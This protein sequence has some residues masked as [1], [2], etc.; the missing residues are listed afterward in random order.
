MIDLFKKVLQETVVFNTKER[1]ARLGG[2]AMKAENVDEW[3]RFFMTNP[4]VNEYGNGVANIID[5]AIVDE[6]GN[7]TS[8]IEKGGLF[9]IK[10]KVLFQEAVDNPIFTFT[11][12]NTQGVAIT[13]SNTRIENVVIEPAQAGDVYVASFTQRMALQGGDYLLSISCTGFVGGEFVVY[14]RLYDLLSVSVVSSKD[15]VGFFDMDS[16]VKV[17]KK[18]SNKF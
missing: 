12:K 5:F 1:M 2:D 16:E 3:K 6:K 14:H 17:E 8:T 10:S 18:K 4:D 11:F 9:T 13:G 15:T 7:L